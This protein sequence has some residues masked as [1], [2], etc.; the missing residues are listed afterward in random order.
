LRII[1]NQTVLSALTQTVARAASTKDSNPALAGMLLR[2]TADGKLTAEATDLDIG[3][4]SSTDEADII[5]EGTVFVNAQYFANLVKNM[6]NQELSIGAD[7]NNLVVKYGKSKATV[8]T[9]NTRDYMDWHIDGVTT[10][11]TCENQQLRDALTNTVFACAKTHFKYVFTGCLFEIGENVVDIVASDTHRLAT[12]QF[13]IEKGEP[14][15]K[16][17]PHRAVREIIRLVSEPG[18][19]TVAT[20]DNSTVVTV[21]NT[22]LI[23]REIEGQYPNWR[24]I[25]PSEFAVE[26]KIQK[27]FLFDALKRMSVIPIDAKMIPV[28]RMKLTQEGQSGCEGIL[29]LSGRSETTGGIQEVI[30]V[31]LLRG[32]EAEMTINTGYLRDF[33]QTAKGEEVLVYMQESNTLPLLLKDAS[34]DGY[35]YVLVPLRTG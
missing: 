31:E 20:T 32:G 19:I 9:L 5:K 3:I 28:T 7:G 11:F 13:P 26:V 6:P 35:K 29:A 1:V 24:A 8:A 4:I 34:V 21:G 17:I 15:Q 18:I 16:I 12:Y 25:I 14:A 27:G 30:D 33:V 22:T 2:A 10:L 23:C